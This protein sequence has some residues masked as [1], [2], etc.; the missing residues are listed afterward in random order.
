MGVVLEPAVFPDGLRR[1]DSCHSARPHARRS[2]VVTPYVVDG[3]GAFVPVV[4][5]ECIAASHGGERGPCRI[6]LQHR[7][8]RQTGPEFP[9]VVVECR[10][11]RVAFTLYPPGHVPYGRVAMA[12]V[13]AAGRLLKAPEAVDEAVEDGTFDIADDDHGGRHP[14][15]LAWA[16]TL[17]GAARDAADG[18]PWPR[19]N[20]I[21][22]GSWRTQGRW[23][24]L[25]ATILGLTA[26]LGEGG[27]AAAN[28]DLLGVSELSRRD[29]A[30]AFAAAP[31]YR[32]RGRAVAMPLV[33]LERAG[34]LLLDWLLVAGFMARCWGAPSRYDPRSGQIRP[35]VPRSRSP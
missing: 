24:V 15:P 21:G 20:S 28:T 35:L 22:P 32:A 12:P 19:C 2:F 17:F 5:A 26:S 9:L 3:G 29:A 14:S 27:S 4:P 34:P 16:A 31:G 1:M 25:G 8:S 6:W 11:H 13:D 18:L 30:E 33:D 23:L 7:R 10:T